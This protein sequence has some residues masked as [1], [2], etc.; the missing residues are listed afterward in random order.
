MPTWTGKWTRSGR[1]KTAL[2]AQIAE[3]GGR[4]AG[5]DSIA[6]NISSAQ[7]LLANLRKRLD[8]PISWVVKRRLIEI[9]VAGVRVETIEECGVRQA[10]TTVTYRFSQ[11]D[12]PMS[13]VMPQSYTT[14]AVIRIPLEPKTIGDHIRKHRLGLNMHQKDVARQIGIDKTSI[15]NWEANTSQPDLRF[16][17]AVIRFLGYNPLP[18]ANTIGEELVRHRTTLGIIQKDAARQIGVDPGTLARW[19]RGERAPTG[20]LLRAAMAFLAASVEALATQR[21]S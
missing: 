5:A 18:P 15:F 3:W 17:P 12:Q 8:E 9:L 21:V 14:G 20:A 19:E 10:R 13:L 1:R 11:P 4:I 16:M 2:E 7:A 6:E